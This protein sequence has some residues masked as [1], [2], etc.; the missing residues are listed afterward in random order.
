MLLVS[1]NFSETTCMKVGLQVR[2]SLVSVLSTGGGE[3]SPLSP[4]KK[5]F[6]LQKIKS[7]L[8]LNADHI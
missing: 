3:A 5:K 4:P 1:N 2:I 8:I 7:H 6:F